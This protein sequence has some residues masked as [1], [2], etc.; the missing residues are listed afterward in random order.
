MPVTSAGLLL[1]RDLGAGVE[2][3]IAHMGGPFWARKHEGAWTVPKGEYEAVAEHPLLAAR[4]EFG[5]EIG[6]APPELD[7]ADLGEFRYASGKLIRVF[8][9]EAPDFDV[10]VVE[11]NT[12]ELEWP[13][14]SGRVQAFPEVDDARW[15]AI[16]GARTLVTKGQVQVLAALETRLAASPPRS[17]E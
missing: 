15:V 4:R 17:V 2:V 6:V 11:S 12:F 13:P 16:D 1:H 5:E 7:Y 3:F 14:R 8:T 10:A 9:G